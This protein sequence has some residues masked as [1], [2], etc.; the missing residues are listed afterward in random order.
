MSELYETVKAE[1]QQITAALKWRLDDGFQLSDVLPTIRDFVGAATVIAETLDVPGPEKKALVVEAAVAWWQKGMRPWLER[2]DAEG[3]PVFNLP[4]PDWMY[5]NM[6][7]MILPT[8][9]GF[10]VDWIVKDRNGVIG[11]WPSV[12]EALSRLAPPEPTPGSETA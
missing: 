8:L 10:M 5:W 6:V 12:G 11:G 4:G 3:K 1:F 9:V 2:V 7:G